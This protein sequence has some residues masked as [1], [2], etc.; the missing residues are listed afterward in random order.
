VKLAAWNVDS[1]EMRLPRDHREGSKPSD[2]A[3]LPVELG[4]R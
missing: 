1:P 2:H 4:E 3:P